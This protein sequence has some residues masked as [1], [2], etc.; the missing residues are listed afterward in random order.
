MKRLMKIGSVLVALLLLALNMTGTLAQGGDAQ[1]RFVHAIPGA[2]AIDIYTDGQLT[3]SGLAYGTATTYINAPAGDHQVTVTATGATNAI[4]QQTIS[5]PNGAAL[6]LV[7]ASASQPSFLVYVDDLS[8]IAAGKARLSAIHAISGGSAVDLVLTD[9]RSVIPGLEFGVQQLPGTLDV[10]SFAYDFAVVPGGQGVD[11][12][13]VT[14]NAVALDSNVSYMLLVYGTAEAPAVLAL[15]ASTQPEA[16]G[17]FVRVVHGVTGGAAVD[18]YVN[19]TLFFPALAAAGYT[20]HVSVAAGE[21][22]V[23]LKPAGGSDTL[24][25]ADVTV[26]SG[27]AITVAAFGSSSDVQLVALEDD[28]AGIEATQAKISL[29]NTLPDS[30]SAAFADGTSI[31]DAV[32]TGAASDAVS[33]AP[34]KQGVTLTINGTATEIPATSFYGGVYYNLVVVENGG[35]P[36]LVVAPTSLAQGLAS[37]PGVPAVAAAPTLAAPPDQAAVTPTVAPV[38]ATAGTGVTGTVFNLNAD[39]NLQLRQY[40]DS[41]ALSLATVP[42][43]TVLVVNGRDGEIV[44]LPNSATPTPPAGYTY[45]DP[46]ST[47]A[48]GEDLDPNSTWL[49]VTYTTTDGGTITAWASALYVD[50]R[51]A[52]GERI[53]LASLPTV[54][55]NQPGEVDNT[56]VTPPPVP[57]DRVAAIVFNLDPG[58]NL[59]IRRTPDVNGEVLARVTNGTV[60]EFLG[61]KEDRQWVFVSYS[62]AE[63]GTVTGWVSATYIQYTYNSRLIDLDELE[64]RELLVTAPDDLR[65][66]VGAGAAPI[67]VP[68]VDPV[69]DQYVAVVALD[70]GS[71]LNLRRNPNSSSEVLAQIPSGT[72]LLVTARTQDELWLQVTFEGT[73]GWIAAKTDVALFVRLTY[74][75]KPVEISA[76]PVFTG[77]VPVPGGTPSVPGTP[78]TPVPGAP[79]AGPTPTEGLPLTDI[80]VKVTD[81]SVQMTGSPGGS[82]DGLPLIFF[83]QEA[84]LLFTDGTFS[85]IQLPDTTRGWVP[86]GAVQPR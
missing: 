42:P 55:A 57:Q 5:A 13:L 60:M 9:G 36:T 48:E 47:L 66:E 83:G 41:A 37:A 64:E 40:P 49:N 8:P 82:A 78:G 43:N 75:G 21:Y 34:S 22:T 65:G 28:I 38:A 27:K 72:Q 26:E 19:D 85:Y 73:V 58:I 84:T 20:Q 11:K 39:R 53:K 14:A 63:G 51:N 86:A 2:S 7:A 50:I 16:D 61:I 6:T 46:A 44:P 12:A 3:A 32:G 62:P 70:A 10:P 54:P 80:P 59:N 1:L 17:G 24:A 45:V 18:V 4:W 30:V 25:T 67:V 33:A 68:T 71:N 29:I 79:T 23:A 15:T 76:V 35:Q 77:E 31:A 69:K 74:N 81:G 52:R 56:A